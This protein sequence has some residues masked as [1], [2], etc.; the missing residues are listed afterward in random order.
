V[1]QPADEDI[2][3]DFISIEDTY[4]ETSQKFNNN[5][6][7]E[8]LKEENHVS[9]HG[10]EGAQTFNRDRSMT[11]IEEEDLEESDCNF[12]LESTLKT[13]K[14]SAIK[15][16]TRDFKETFETFGDQGLN[17][18]S[19]KGRVKC[20]D[21]L[22][23]KEMGLEDIPNTIETNPTTNKTLGSVPGS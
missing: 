2:T 5:G 11:I 8:S 19:V 23:A 13:S 9:L 21:Y 14:H 16:A 4:K 6:S 3:D 7:H 18:R 20:G 15:M 22:L 10:T 12:R 1:I 17:P